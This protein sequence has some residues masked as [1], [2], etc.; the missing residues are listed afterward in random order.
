MTSNEPAT[1]QNDRTN[2]TFPRRLDGKVALVIGGTGA[3]G[4]ATAKLLRDA[5]AA[6][7]VTYREH[8]ECPH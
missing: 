8:V 5:G 7:I 3:I 4:T 2:S 6:V 1:V